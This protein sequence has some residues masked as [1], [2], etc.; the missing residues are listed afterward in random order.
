MKILLINVVYGK[1]STGRIIKDIS[2]SCNQ[3]GITAYIA[4]G[5]GNRIPSKYI[6]KFCSEFEAALT[7]IL[8]KLGRLMYGGAPIATL[9]LIRKIREI[10]PDLVH[11]HCI[12]GY[13][14]NI[15]QLLNFLAIN[16][17]KTLITNHAEFFYTGNCGHAIECN[18]FRNREGCGRCPIYSKATGSLFCDRSRTAWKKMKENF[19]K[20]KNGSL[21]FSAVSPWVKQRFSSSPITSSYECSVVM[22]GIDVNIFKRLDE[23]N[24]IKKFPFSNQSK[25]MLYVTASFSDSE[26]SI[27]GGDKLLELARVMP[28][29][30]FII[31]ATYSNIKSTLPPNVQFYGPIATTKEL[32]QFYNEA[33]LTVITSKRETFSMIVAESLCC[34]TPVI[35][36]KAGGPDSIAL[37]K[38]SK[39]VDYGDIEA[40][41]HAAIEML[42]INFDRPKIA[43]EAASIYSRETMTDQYISLYN[44][45]LNK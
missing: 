20:F 26:N 14:I 25:N 39:F 16:N 4:Y 36:F 15:Y 3:K 21:H 6:Y 35:G 44:K 10:N 42:S 7:K 23:T 22:N 45:L 19:D 38:Y 43:K 27:K 2:E 41:H 33:D 40:L 8:N 17:I 5:R 13:C 9:K 24:I 32:A 12:N 31:V 1:G 11:I 29:Y 34:G 30:N 37:N 28:N 18:R